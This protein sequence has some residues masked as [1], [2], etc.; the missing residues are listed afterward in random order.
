MLNSPVPVLFLHIFPVS[1]GDNQR[2]QREWTSGKYTSDWLIY[3][4]DRIFTPVLLVQLLVGL[5]SNLLRSIHSSGWINSSYWDDQFVA[6]GISIRILRDC[7]VLLGLFWIAI[8]ESERERKFDSVISLVWDDLLGKAC[9]ILF[10]SELT[11]NTSETWNLLQVPAVCD[12]EATAAS[13]SLQY[14]NLFI[15]YLLVASSIPLSQ[16]VINT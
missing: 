13:L 7:H 3:K 11:P 15:Q 2:T 12:S 6:I 1:D 8:R 4:P 16:N 14:G 5:I 9:K 10:F